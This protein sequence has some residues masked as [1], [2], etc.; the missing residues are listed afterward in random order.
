[1]P[2]ASPF[3]CGWLADCAVSRAGASVDISAK[4]VPNGDPD[5]AWLDDDAA[6][7]PADWEP[8]K[9]TAPALSGGT[10]AG[11]TA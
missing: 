8:A 10:A 6:Y 3:A 1:L 9:L 2:R 7:L 5:E 11:I 4:T